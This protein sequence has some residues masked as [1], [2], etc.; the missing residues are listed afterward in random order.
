MLSA[1]KPRHTTRRIAPELDACVWAALDLAQRTTLGIA[2]RAV[3]RAASRSVTVFAVSAAWRL[4][5]AVAEWAGEAVPS[6]PR[7]R[8]RHGPV[9]IAAGANSAA[10][11]YRHVSLAH[12]GPSLPQ[13]EQ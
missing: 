1:D 13:R 8:T 11:L 4:A 12:S 2:R 9:A 5:G 3:I 10:F 7:R 6:R